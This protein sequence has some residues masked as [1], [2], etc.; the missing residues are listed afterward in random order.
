VFIV[1]FC[2]EKVSGA[3]KKCLAHG[4]GP[5][6]GLSGVGD[7]ESEVGLEYGNLF[8]SG[9]GFTVE[10]AVLREVGSAWKMWTTPTA[11]ASGGRERA[12]RVNPEYQAVIV[13]RGWGEG[14]KGRYPIALRGAW[15]IHP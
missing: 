4:M 11:S 1:R 6:D 5:G 13:P 9:T 7:I 8:N 3:G 12:S 14:S 10:G 2:G 15:E